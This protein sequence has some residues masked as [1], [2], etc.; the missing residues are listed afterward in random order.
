MAL[1]ILPSAHDTCGVYGYTANRARSRKI[2]DT[3]DLCAMYE[4]HRES[5]DRPRMSE[6]SKLVYRGAEAEFQEILDKIDKGH[7]ITI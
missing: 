1:R 3:A 5:L 6:L 4:R 2:Q 7:P